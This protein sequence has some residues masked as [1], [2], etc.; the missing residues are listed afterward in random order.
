MQIHLLNIFSNI[1]NTNHLMLMC[2]VQ[3]EKFK[4]PYKTIGHIR[5]VNFEIKELYFEYLSESLSILN[6][7]YVTIPISNITF[8]YIIKKGLCT[9]LNKNFLKDL[10]NKNLAF[11]LKQ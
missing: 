5:K 10:T 3:F 1:K 2:K 11:Q 7:S 6:D 4:F 8:S 9:E